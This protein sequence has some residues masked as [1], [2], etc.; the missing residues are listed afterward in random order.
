MLAVRFKIHKEKTIGLKN[1]DSI[2]INLNFD[3][4]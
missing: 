3:L 2:K 4:Y 1:S